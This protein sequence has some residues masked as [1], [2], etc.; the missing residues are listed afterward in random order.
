M[1]ISAIYKHGVFMPE[2][3]VSL[4]EGTRAD[5]T[6]KMSIEEKI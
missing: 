3:P 4:P 6:P 1:S 2:E 5:I